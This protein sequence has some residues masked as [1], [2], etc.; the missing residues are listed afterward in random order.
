MTESFGMQLDDDSL[1]ALFSRVM[2]HPSA[3][4]TCYEGCMTCLY[5]ALVHFKVQKHATCC[6]QHEYI[7]SHG[8][9]LQQLTAIHDTTGPARS[10]PQ[11]M[12]GSQ[13]TWCLSL[14]QGTQ[15]FVM[16]TAATHKLQR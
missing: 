5:T 10:C 4:L 9:V 3:T 15:P 2:T 13:A 12:A 16:C 11:A 6:I 1:L 7:G 8:L 14:Y